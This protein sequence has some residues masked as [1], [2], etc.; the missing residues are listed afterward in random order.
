MKPFRNV[1]TEKYLRSLGFSYKSFNQADLF[2]IWP[3]TIFAYIVNTVWLKF[4][5]IWLLKTSFFTHSI[6]LLLDLF[7]RKWYKVCN[8]A[9]SKGSKLLCAS[10][11]NLLRLHALKLV[12]PLEANF[13]IPT[14][15]TKV[16]VPYDTYIALLLHA[17]IYLGTVFS[18]SATEKKS[19]THF[20]CKPVLLSKVAEI[21]P[22]F[23]F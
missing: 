11:S 9:N 22:S 10:N 6:I 20:E 18:T 3:N 12:C 17:T 7:G 4:W 13:Q 23:N 5:T 1:H 8:A 14:E 19:W 21:V 15:M 16:F 2:E